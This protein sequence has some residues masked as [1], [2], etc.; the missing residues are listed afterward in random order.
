LDKSLL[1]TTR[2]RRWIVTNQSREYFEAVAG[3]W[4]EI[5]KGL[6][7]DELRETV[8]RAAA[9][10][11]GLV[12]A[13]LGAGTGFLTEELLAH[14]ARVIAVDQAEGMLAAL[15]GKLGAEAGDRLEL[16]AGGA[17]ALP[18][19]DGSVD[20]VV[21]NMF[22]HH[23]DDPAAAL[24]EA[25]RVLRPGGRIVIADLD[26]HHHEFLLVEQHD[27][28][29]GFERSE[30]AGWLAAAGFDEIDIRDA[31]ATCCGCSES[32]GETA[33]ITVFLATADL[34]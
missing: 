33:R 26:F 5:R 28:W 13:D 19:P 18:L 24:R 10:R 23:V 14:G 31:R 22:L 25:A 16:R 21:A 30:V 27:R 3:E 8:A 9:L 4:D 32:C 20:R 6:F 11:P 1:I 12:A 15:G 29:P 7:P 2:K 17:E 34:P